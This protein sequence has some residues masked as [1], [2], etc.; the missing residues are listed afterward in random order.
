MARAYYARKAA[1]C[2]DSHR[3]AEGNIIVIL[4]LVARKEPEKKNGADSE[5]V[6]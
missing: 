1:G 6:K 4:I 3:R 5:R 2:M